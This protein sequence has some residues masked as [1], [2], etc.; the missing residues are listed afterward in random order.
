MKKLM[1]YRHKFTTPVAWTLRHD[2]RIVFHRIEFLE[3][4]NTPDGTMQLVRIQHNTELANPDNDVAV[5][6]GQA[7]LHRKSGVIDPQS[8][9]LWFWNDKFW[10][11]AR[12]SDGTPYYG[13]K[14]YLLYQIEVADQE[15]LLEQITTGYEQQVN[16]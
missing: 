6:V 7:V 13:K 8:P 11:K 14:A 15:K 2:K 1:A 10:I 12:A 5:L 4:A 3:E 16:E 9:E